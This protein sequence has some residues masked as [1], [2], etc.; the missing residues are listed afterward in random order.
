[1]KK[2]TNNNS[3]ATAV[4]FALIAFPL[5][6]LIMGIIEF[7]MIYFAN[8]II[9]NAAT[10][11]S[12]LGITGD[13]YV[14]DADVAQG[15]DRVDMIRNNII[16]QSGGFLDSDKISITCQN[17][18]NNF[19][20]IPAGSGDGKYT[21]GS[22]IDNAASCNDAG[23]GGQIV[24]YNVA[25]CWKLITPLAGLMN[26]LVSGSN[27]PNEILLNSSLLVLNENFQ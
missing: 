21:C 5:F 17:L 25:Y 11:S 10:I 19:A 20:G 23:A 16:A 22:A 24:I 27:T 12:R 14:G 8:S 6:L 13:E 7:S 4:E 9:E 3:G 2:I 26:G 18:G 1:M 15:D